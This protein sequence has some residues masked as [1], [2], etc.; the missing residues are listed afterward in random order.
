LAFQLL[1]LLSLPF[2]LSL[3]FFQAPLLL[4]LNLF[5]GLEL[6]ANCCST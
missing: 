1:D 2:N 5:L 6:S 4:G 3:L